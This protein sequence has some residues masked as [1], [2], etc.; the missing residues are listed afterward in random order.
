MD[1]PDREDWPDYYKLIKAPIALS[2]IRDRVKAGKYRKWE[3]FEAE[4]SRVF[5]N[6]K[7]YNDPD[8]EVYEDADVME[9]LLRDL[10]RE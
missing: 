9:S 7:K 2:T 4:L 3:L 10:A 8:S 5:S 6:A 1:L